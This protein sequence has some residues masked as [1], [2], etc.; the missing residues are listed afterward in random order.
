MI[1]LIMAT[2][3]YTHSAEKLNITLPHEMIQ[4]IQDKVGSGDYSCKSEVIREALWLLQTQETVQAGKLAALKTK[5]DQSINGDGSSLDAEE[6]F[7]RLV[8]RH[9]QSGT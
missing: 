1:Y 9:S 4:M 6:V 7:E 3:K 2:E 8:K 5:V